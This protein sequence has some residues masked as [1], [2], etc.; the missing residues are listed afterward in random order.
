[1]LPF[2]I[3]ET[4]RYFRLNKKTLTLPLLEKRRSSTTKFCHR[5]PWQISHRSATAK[6]WPNLTTGLATASSLQLAIYIF[7][8]RK[9]N[10][11][12]H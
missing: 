2:L 1:M 4:K 9:H 7:F 3:R 6:Q 5:Q 12:Y 10:D 11:S 8:K